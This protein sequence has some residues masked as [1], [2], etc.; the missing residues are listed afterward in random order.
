MYQEFEAVEFCTHVGDELPS[1]QS[2]RTFRSG[3]C[4]G[5]ARSSVQE[6]L[7]G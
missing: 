2:I 4:F 5:L 3:G 7:R 1:K 6:V